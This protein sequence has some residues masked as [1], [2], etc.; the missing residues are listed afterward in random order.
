MTIYN[1]T[2]P[3]DNPRTPPALQRALDRIWARMEVRGVDFFGDGYLLSPDEVTHIAR[4]EM[5]GVDDLPI[6]KKRHV[7]EHGFHW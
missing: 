7:W 6:Y 5:Y 4:D 3:R 2:R 1:G